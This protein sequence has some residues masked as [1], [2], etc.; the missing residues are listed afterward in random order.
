MLTFLTDI[1]NQEVSIQS[2]PEFSQTH[3][4]AKIIVRKD[5][6][7]YFVFKLLSKYQLVIMNTQGH[8]NQSRG[9]TRRRVDHE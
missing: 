7:G 1:G 9:T 3:F 5:K 2:F 6:S 4:N 8:I